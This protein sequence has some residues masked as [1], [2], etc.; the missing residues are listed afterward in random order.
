MALSVHLPMQRVLAQAPTPT[1]TPTP[2]NFGNFVWDDFDGDGI[3]DAGEPGLAGVIVQLW[4]STKT[5][6]IDSAV[7]N[8]NGNYTVQSAGPGN[9]RVRVVLPHILDSFSPMNQG[10]NDTTDSDINP[11]GTN[12]GFTDIYAIAS[13]VIS[14]SS[15]DAGIRVY[16]TPTPTRTPTPVNFGNF[17]WDDLDGDGIQDAGEPGLAGVTVQ[18]WNS[19]KTQ[20]IDSAVTNAN[21]N[22]TVQ[23]AGPGNYRVRV[24]LPHILD[25]FSPMNQGANDTTDSDINPSGTNLG[26]TDI[27]A[28][29]SNVISISSIDA[30]IR[31]YRTP[32]PTRTPTPVNVG[33]FVWHDLDGDGIQDAGEPG[34]AGVTVQL[35]NSTKTQLIDSAVTNANGNYTVQAAGPGNYRVRVILPGGGASFSPKNQGLSDTTDS[36]INPSGVDLGFTDVY[37]FAS[38]L[39]SITSI[40]AGLR[41][42]STVTPTATA[43]RTHTR[44]PIPAV[45]STPVATATRTPT[46]TVMKG[47]TP[48]VTGTSASV[49]TWPRRYLPLVIR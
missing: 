4:N 26:F 31:V 32:T 19:T 46:P 13:N 25:S 10:A 5:Q 18:L 41:N 3:Q 28:I 1:R 43:T 17:V 6:L 20:L 21:G 35:W 8:A 38:N 36:D 16:R 33:N 23:S 9:Y 39:I 48:A 40:D 11:S 30:G 15:I 45:T 29:A 2:V 37:V 12:L 44:T 49:N 42:V 7:T 14:I 22:Y 34:V 24:V 47:L 27:Y